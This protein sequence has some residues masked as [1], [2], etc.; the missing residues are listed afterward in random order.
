MS[1]N[2]GNLHWCLYRRIPNHSRNPH[3]SKQVS[4][5]AWYLQC[6]SLTSFLLEKLQLKTLAYTM[7]H[8]SVI[9]IFRQVSDIS[10]LGFL[11][12]QECIKT[13]NVHKRPDLNAS[14]ER[15][16]LREHATDDC[17][18]NVQG[19]PVS[20]GFVSVRSGSIQHNVRT[21]CKSNLHSQNTGAERL[22]TILTL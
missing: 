22:I 3:F 6:Y 21:H 18:K 11:F 5:R 2:T 12:L 14:A 8:K 13:Y 1:T 10:V 9:F 15:L 19:R 4:N 7:R 16:L 20:Y 17:M